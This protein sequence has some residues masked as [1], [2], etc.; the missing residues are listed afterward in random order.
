[1][2]PKLGT[3][4]EL[5]QAFRDAMRGAQ[6]SPLWPLMRDVLPHDAPKAVTL[7][8]HWRY[9][10]IRP[11]LLEAGELAPVEKSERRVLVLNDPGRGSG[12]MQVTSSIYVG[13]Q[14][15]LPGE[16]APAHRHTPSA[17]RIMVEGEG[18]Y[19]VVNGEKCP[20][21]RGDLVLTPGGFWHDHGHEGDEPAIWLDALDLPLFVY[22]EGSYSV[23]AEMQAARNRPDASEVEYS[24]PGLVPVR[25]LGELANRYPLLR[26]PW[27][28]TRSALISMDRYAGNGGAV[29]LAYVN[30][31]TG[32]S[33]LPTLGFC[34]TLL[35]PGK[36]YLLP[37][38]SASAVFHVI[39][40]VGRTIVNGVSIDWSV[41][42]VFSAPAFAEIS[43]VAG[44]N[45]PAFLMRIDD[46]PLQIRLGFYEE[47]LRA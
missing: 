31:E 25:P 20:M 34:A 1:M 38:R 13:L 46:A 39:E 17:A 23:E 24:R 6:V 5:P 10:E 18:A 7:P 8:G 35:Q 33:C 21:H 44:G 45:S 41:G 15:L 43:H 47:R 12:A 40:G 32:G 16:K 26:Y 11:L 36:C 14:L 29:E 4:E 30:P 42:D 2:S 28:S 27:E 19:T 3:V 37:R 9:A 22:L